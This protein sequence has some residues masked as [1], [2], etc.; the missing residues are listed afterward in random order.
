MMPDTTIA[1]DSDALRPAISALAT[2][3]ARAKK[4]TDTE[5]R[6][7]SLTASTAI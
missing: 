6:E 1:V 7:L 5:L 2:L 3:I 4:P